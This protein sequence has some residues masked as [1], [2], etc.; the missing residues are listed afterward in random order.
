MQ[1]LYEKLRKD[2]EKWRKEGYPCQKYPLIGE[3]LQ[4]QFEGDTEERGHP[5]IPARTP[6]SILRGILV[7]PTGAGNT[8]NR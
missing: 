5:Q 4:W 6:I 2:A 3:I 1:Q 8:K 7:P